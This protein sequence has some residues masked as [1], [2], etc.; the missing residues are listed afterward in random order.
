MILVGSVMWENV[1][2]MLATIHAGDWLVKT[3]LI[4]V[5]LGVWRKGGGASTLTF[6]LRK[7]NG[8]WAITHVH[9][10]LPGEQSAKPAN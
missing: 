7:V 6:E 8:Q 5:I 10:S 2:W 4:A 3:L 1:P 9:N